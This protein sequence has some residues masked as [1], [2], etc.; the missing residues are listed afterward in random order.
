[1]GTKDQEARGVKMKKKMEE[2]WKS[3]G[4]DLNIDI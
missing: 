2:L 3:V 1:M 4:A